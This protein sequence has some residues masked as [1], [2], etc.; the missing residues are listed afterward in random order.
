MPPIT[1]GIGNWV[2]T[3]VLGSSFTMLLLLCIHRL[4]DGSA[5]TCSKNTGLLSPS[6]I[7]NTFIAPVLGSILTTDRLVS[8]VVRLWVIQALPA[9]SAS[10]SCTPTAPCMPVEGPW[11]QSEPL[12]QVASLARSAIGRSY[13]VTTALAASPVGRGSSLSYRSGELGPRTSARYLAS[14]SR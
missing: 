1:R 9:A 6:V 14:S 4:P 8:N 2:N 7:L 13:S 12:N 10:T 5:P 3:S 11:L